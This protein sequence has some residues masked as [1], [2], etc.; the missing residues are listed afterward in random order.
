MISTRAQARL[1]LREAEVVFAQEF[2]P[3][4]GKLG[5]QITGRV[6]SKMREDRGREKANVRHRI[7]GSSYRLKLVVYGDLE[8]TRVD[9]E[10]RQK[11]R[12]YSRLAGKRGVISYTGMPPWKRGSELYAWVGRKGFVGATL[13][14]TQRRTVRFERRTF[15]R[16]EGKLRT[17]SQSAQQRQ[18]SIAYLIARKIARDGIKPR[19][20]FERTAEEA[21]GFVRLTIEAAVRSSLKRLDA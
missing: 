3:A 10:G 15:N 21:R 4:L 19:K 16:K 5:T 1:F 11:G 6:R 20:P 2:R 14:K 7:T 9:E 8:Q 12:P 13:L 18:E 17:R